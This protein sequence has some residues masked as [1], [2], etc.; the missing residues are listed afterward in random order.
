MHLQEHVM[1]LKIIVTFSNN[2]QHIDF[3][4]SFNVDGGLP[5][6]RGRQRRNSKDITLFIHG[7][8]GDACSLLAD[9]A[10]WDAPTWSLLPSILQPLAITIRK[11]YELAPN[12]FSI[13][14]VF[15]GDI[16]TETISISINELL[17]IVSAGKLGNKVRYNVLVE[18][19][20]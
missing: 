3:N 10:D 9:D 13:T 6:T 11:L 19:Y 2:N 5:F 16:A 1:C 8:D 20:T 15:G 14:A 12:D 7:Y 17:E 18:K 4:E